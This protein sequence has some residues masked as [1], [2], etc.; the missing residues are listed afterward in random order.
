MTNSNIRIR[1]INYILA[2]KCFSMMNPINEYGELAANY[3][4][5]SER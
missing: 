2:I 1:T 3:K 4:Q 5:V